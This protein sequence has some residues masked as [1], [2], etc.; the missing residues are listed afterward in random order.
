MQT[1]KKG[2]RTDNNGNMVNFDNTD[3][4]GL[5][6]NTITPIPTDSQTSG[7]SYELIL[8]SE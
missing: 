6:I 4:N 3:E 8:E 7:K 2:K 5:Y 1:Q